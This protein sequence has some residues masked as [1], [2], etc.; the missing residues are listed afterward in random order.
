MKLL[1][2]Q[3]QDFYTYPN[4]DQVQPVNAFYL[5]KLAT[6]KHFNTKPDETVKVQYFDL[7][8]EPPKFF[9]DQHSEMWQLIKNY[10]EQ[11]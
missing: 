4:G 2:L 8:K 9:N 11:L 7:A 3:D 5:V 1:K 10:V 6:Q